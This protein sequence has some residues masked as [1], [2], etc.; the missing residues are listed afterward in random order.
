MYSPPSPVR[1]VFVRNRHAGERGRRGDSRRLR[2]D[3]VPKT[4]AAR[5]GDTL[6][7][8]PARHRAADAQ[9]ISRTIIASDYTAA[10]LSVK[11]DEIPATA[12]ECS[13]TGRSA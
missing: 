1:Q 12:N 13:T 7:T 3:A 8:H 5:F 11:Y 6:E 2:E 9:E 4:D 10:N